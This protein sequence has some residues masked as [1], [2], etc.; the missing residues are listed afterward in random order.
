MTSI[1]AW[2]WLP[3][4]NNG[5]I[6][7][8]LIRTCVISALL[9][10]QFPQ[11]SGQKIMRVGFDYALGSQQFF[12]FNDP[13]YYRR[14]NGY[15]MQLYYPFHPGKWSLELLVEPSVYIA[16]QRLLRPDYVTESA[17][18]PD[19]LELRTIYGAMRT[20]HE[21]TVNF[22]F[23]PRYNFNSVFCAFFLISTGPLYVDKTTERLAGGFAFS[24]VVAIGGG[25]SAGRI[26]IELRT[27]MRHVSNLGT[28]YPNKGHNT[29]TIDIGVSYS[30]KKMAQI[31]IKD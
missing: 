17:Y 15:K 1:V 5:R 28:Q 23:L 9:F 3:H 27:G 31:L 7:K 10:S 21:Y 6:I 19:Y 12:P 8:H 4:R 20:I 11:A 2:K 25:Y 14:T 13:V 29:S 16:R 26:R 24:D 22:G 30:L 18:G